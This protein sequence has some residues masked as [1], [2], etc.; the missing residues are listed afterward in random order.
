[1][2]CNVTDHEFAVLARSVLVGLMYPFVFFTKPANKIFGCKIIEWFSE[3]IFVCKGILRTYMGLKFN[4][5][6]KGKVH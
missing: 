5:G 2:V 4:V 6:R 3:G 1:M